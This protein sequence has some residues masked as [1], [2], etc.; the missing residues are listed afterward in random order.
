MLHTFFDRLLKEE[1]RLFKQVEDAAKEKESR[2][3]RRRRHGFKP[4]ER[5]DADGCFLDPV[6][7]LEKPVESKVH[8]Y[9]TCSCIFD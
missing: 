1:E 3:L 7:E 4:P 9:Y 8:T 6:S 5:T 2:G